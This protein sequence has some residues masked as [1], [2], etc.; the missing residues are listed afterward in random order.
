MHILKRYIKEYYIDVISLNDKFCPEK[1][2]L[3]YYT[4]FS[5]Y[6]KRPCDNKKVATVTSHKCLNNMKKTLQV[7]KVFDAVS[8]NSLILFN[9]F[10]DKVNGL[11][12]TPSGVDTD[13]FSFKNKSRSKKLV[14]GWVGNVDRAV[15]NYHS[16]MKPL[17]KKMSGVIFKEVATYKKSKYNDLLNVEEMKDFYHALAFLLITSSAE[18][19]PNPGLEALSCG[20]PVISTRVGNMAEIVNDSVGGFLCEDNLKSFI[21]CIND[22]KDISENR[23]YYMSAAAR[24]SVMEWDWSIIYKKYI[25]F[26]NRI[27][28]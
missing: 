7:L 15:K 10:K 4:H 12:Y 6:K 19:T 11:C 14:M 20:V 27:A 8:V 23:Y 25:D 2:D 28:I 26:F 9:I 18:G 17:K 3:V 21:S 22:N 13:H 24:N 16:I 1:Y 5:L